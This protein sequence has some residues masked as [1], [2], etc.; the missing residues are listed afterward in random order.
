VIGLRSS[1]PSGGAYLADCR[2]WSVF[3]PVNL[4]SAGSRTVSGVDAD[5]GAIVA[6]LADQQAELRDLVL[7]IDQSDWQRASR[8]EGWTVADVVLHLAQ[9][10]ELA[11]ASANGHFAEAVDRLTGGRSTA[12][13]VDDGADLMVARDRD[14][15]G[16]AVGDRW[17]ASTR[18]L[19]DVLRASDPDAR[20]LWVAGELSPRTLAT[21]RL[22][23]TW[24]HT[25]DVAAAFGTGLPPT[26]RLW[27]IARLAWRTLPYA[28]SRAGRELKGPV[29]FELQA[30]GG[31]LWDFSPDAGSLT[32]I[33]GDAVD[34]CLVAARRADPAETGLRG[35]GPD[36]LGVLELVRTYA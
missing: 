14:V 20:F 17:Q 9:T 31:D 26:D 28:F 7:A 2:C 1:A 6:A 16:P 30:P 23:E 24:I 19:C 36:A 32:R 12:A 34:L 10:N 15:P 18:A 27:H 25:G 5:L 22:A 29:A 13:S 3:E 11:I 4:R 21:T 8:C 33:H 35:E